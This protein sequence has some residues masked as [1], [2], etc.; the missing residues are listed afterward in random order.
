MT[1][2][3]MTR[4]TFLQ[5]LQKSGIFTPQQFQAVCKDIPSNADAKAIAQ[6][7]IKSKKLTRFQAELLLAGKTKGF[8]VGQYVIQYLVGKGGLGRVYKALQRTMNRAVALKVLHPELIQSD[9]S[10][11]TKKARDLFH[12]EVLAAGKLH[13]PNIA[14]AFDANIT[15]NRVYLVMEFVDGLNLEQL[16]RKKGALRTSLA[17]EIIRQ[18]SAALQCAFEKGM[19]HRDIKPANILVQKGQ[20][21]GSGVCV[22]VVDFGLARLQ[23][24]G[25]EPEDGVGT[26][27]TRGNTVMGTPDFLSPEQARSL[28]DVDIRSD[29]YSLGCTM[30]Y[31][32]AGDVPFPGG[33]SLEKMIRQTSEDPVPLEHVRTDISPQVSAIVRRLMAKDR[34]HRFQTPA[35]LMQALLPFCAGSSPALPL[36]NIAK[37]VRTRSNDTNPDVS[38]PTPKP[39]LAHT[40]VMGDGPE[41]IVDDFSLSGSHSSDENPKLIELNST[42]SKRSGKGSSPVWVLIGLCVLFGVLAIVCLLLFLGRF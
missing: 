1:S 35:E 18:A 42:A 11:Q 15:G 33:T 10:E 30:Y 20:T 41:N 31:L 27:F 17:C 22:K 14:T 37:E 19:L 16:V 9:D 25:D 38:S 34:N 36:H 7:L 5:H 8:V 24:P 2:T 40:P 39:N 13:H 12:R 3:Q 26:I 4:N 21:G 6:S 28:H 29:L 23:A 32:L